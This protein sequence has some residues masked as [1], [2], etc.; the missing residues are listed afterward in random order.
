MNK[1]F[2]R[3]FI[4]AVMFYIPCVRSVCQNS[5]VFTVEQ[6]VE[7]AMKNSRTLKS[8]DID[9]EI[10]KRASDYSWNVLVPTLQ[11]SGTLSRQNDISSSID[12]A[13]ASLQ[14]ANA[15]SALL[16]TAPSKPVEETESMHWAA[17]GNLS[18]SWNFSLAYIEQIKA[19]KYDY[20]TGLITRKQSMRETEVNVKKLF[21]G[22][23]LQQENIKLQKVM[24]ENARRR[25][26]QAY[27]N[28]ENGSVPELSYL[29]NYVSYEN[30][31]PAVADAERT[32]R[33][34][35]DTFAFIL[36]LPVG[37]DIVLD[38]SI[39][40]DY[41]DAMADEL[42]SQYGANSL[43]LQ[44]LSG[45]KKTLEANLRALNLGS[46]APSFAFNFGF[47]PMIT[48][49]FNSDKSWGDGDNWKDNGSM[50]FTLA[51]NITEM[52]PFSS[53][54]QKAQDLKSNIKKLELSMETLKENQKLEVK[55]ALDTMK[56]AR[57]QIAAMSRNITLAQRS[58]E[59]AESAYQAGVT[60]LLSL[61][62]SETQL[63]QARLALANQKFNYISAMLD[64]E[65]ILNTNLGE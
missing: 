46:F 49:A 15:F 36:G 61:R 38:G 42:I 55:K 41:I 45:S 63:Y 35:L 54:R 24:L 65:K 62:D 18:V 26:N 25:S 3:I 31:K 53:S 12:S 17:V 34:Q 39:E 40:P 10:K 33:Q 19:A 14:M 64:L 57:E 27:M 16:G 43:D 7:Y 5:T 29:Q 48:D 51:W 50:S 23:L 56:S 28:Y 6:A 47:Q 13:N 11:A 21:Y 60:E 9:L 4:F 1:F 22:L 44:S 58:Y 30:Q 59:M 37:T 8:A 20:E 2:I 52:L 32:F